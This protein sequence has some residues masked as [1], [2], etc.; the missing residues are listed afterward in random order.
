MR[1]STFV[2]AQFRRPAPTDHKTV[3]LT[4]G[5]VAEAIRNAT[6]VDQWDRSYKGSMALA[7]D[8]IR[9]LIESGNV[10]ALNDKRYRL[11]SPDDPPQESP[12]DFR[13]PVPE[14]RGRCGDVLDLGPDPGV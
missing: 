6:D 8:Q 13:D 7:R 5:L 4:V 2:L 10:V 11:A 9:R 14:A 1:L 3:Y 12:G